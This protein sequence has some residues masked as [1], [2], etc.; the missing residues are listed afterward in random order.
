MFSR[1]SE[2]ILSISSPETIGNIDGQENRL[3][4]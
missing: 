1:N 2:A 4:V 3:A